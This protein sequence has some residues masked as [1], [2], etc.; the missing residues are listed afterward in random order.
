MSIEHDTPFPDHAKKQLQERYGVEF[1]GKQWFDFGRTL[2]NPN[3]T[4]Q[5]SDAGQGR[6]FCACY[7]M[8]HWYL[9]VR[10]RDGTV[11]TAYPRLDITEED[12]RML[13]RDERYRRI[14]ND[15]FRVWRNFP[16]TAMPLRRKA[17][18]L[19]ENV[20]LPTEVSQSA[21]SFLERFCDCAESYQ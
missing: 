16:E 11:A 2:C 21:E 8:G 4:I 9:L 18:A 12:K 7:F 5:L 14:N 19:P 6:Y 1:V 3:W 15:E 17:I 20:E 10:A 13:M